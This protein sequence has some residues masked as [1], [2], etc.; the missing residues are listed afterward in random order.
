MSHGNIEIVRQVYDAWAHGVRPGPPA[1]LD[2]SIAY[3]NPA[4]AVEPGTRHG[5]TAF[6]QAVEKTFEGWE[7]WQMEPEELK[8]SG[9]LVAVALRY[10]ARGRSSG[11]E[12]EGRE[13]ALWTIREGKVVRYQWFQEPLDAFQAAGLASRCRRRTWRWWRR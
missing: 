4:G 2:A 8:A 10:R 9:D 13:S 6:A 5:L 1:L 3:V 7:T 12:V 11:L